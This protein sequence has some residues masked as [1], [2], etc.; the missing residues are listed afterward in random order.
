M[1]QDTDSFE[2]CLEL[3]SLDLAS[4]G[5]HPSMEDL[6]SMAWQDYQDGRDYSFAAQDIAEELS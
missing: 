5:I 6:A 2:D 3:L 4:R 1:H